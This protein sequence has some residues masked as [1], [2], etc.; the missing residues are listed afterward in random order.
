VQLAVAAQHPLVDERFALLGR[1]HHVRL[2]V[3]GPLAELQ[4]DRREVLL[5]ALQPDVPAP[6]AG[7]TPV[8]G[9]HHL[10]LGE[11][12]RQ[13][14]VDL[15]LQPVELLRRRRRQELRVV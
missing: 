9:D 1:R 11:R 6:L 15:A 12:L 3:Q 5:D 4:P 8:E 2:E 10:V 14:A 7:L 13:P